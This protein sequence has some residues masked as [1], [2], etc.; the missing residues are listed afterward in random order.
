MLREYYVL[1]KPGIIRGN[2]MNA[3]AGFLLASTGAINSWLL[4]ATLIGTGLVIACG[5][6]FNSYLDRHIDARMQRTAKRPLVTGTISVRRALVFGTLLGLAGF[7]I[8][9]QWVNALVVILGAVALVSY[10]AVYGYY[11]RRTTYGT[12]VGTLPGA[13]PAVAGYAAVT[14]R[15]DTAA[16]LLFIILAAWQMAH[17]YAIGIYRHA[18]Y[19]AAGLPI[20]PVVRGD[21]RATLSVYGYIIAFGAACALLTVFGY[22]GMVFLSVMGAICIIWLAVGLRTRTSVKPAA[23][24]KRMFLFSLI[25][26]L[27]LAVMLAVGGRLP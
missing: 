11:K 3:A 7:L 16:L 2:V 14:G 19:H 5:C 20:L 13:L 21:H 1:T 24:G 9:A 10:V 4:L 6:V 15:L 18:D 23:W 17:F 8:L 27:L 22:T 12:L 26:I 25:V